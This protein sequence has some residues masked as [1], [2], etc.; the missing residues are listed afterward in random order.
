M[1]DTEVLRHPPLS[2][3]AIFVRYVLFAVAAGIAN[4]LTQATISRA[5]P[6]VTVVASIL[7]GTAVGFLVKY[8]LDKRWVFFD[9][10]QDAIGEI[11]KITAYGAFGVATTLMFWGVELGAWHAWKTAEAKY[12]GAVVGLAIGNWAKYLLDKRFVFSGRPW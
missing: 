4:I 6:N 7:A 1:S 9:G 5:S 12:I 2:G 3:A 11:R 8:V 10:Y